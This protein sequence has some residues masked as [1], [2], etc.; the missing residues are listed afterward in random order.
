MSPMAANPAT[1]PP[2]GDQDR[3]LALMALYW[4]F[5]IVALTT[6]LLRMYA[7]RMIN[8]LGRDD[9]IMA[10]TTVGPEQSHHHASLLGDIDGF[11]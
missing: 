10:F 9:W 2:G 6:T 8:G 4:V 3:G 7:R 1:V 5:C 11:N